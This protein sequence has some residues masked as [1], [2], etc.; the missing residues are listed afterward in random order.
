V[1][2]PP[3]KLPPGHRAVAQQPTIAGLKDDVPIMSSLMR[4][5][6]LTF[7]GRCGAPAGRLLRRAAG[8]GAR[9]ASM[10]ACA[11]RSAVP[12]PWGQCAKQHKAAK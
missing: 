8:P 11:G 4:P 2:L 5:K 3:G 7:I 10:Q 1:D 12:M 6:K 9:G